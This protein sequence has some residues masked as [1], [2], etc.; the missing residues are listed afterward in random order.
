MPRD[1]YLTDGERMQAEHV[2]RQAADAL[3]LAQRNVAM[4]VT[5]NSS[6]LR[7]FHRQAADQ[8]R[9]DPDLVDAAEGLGAI[10]E[11]LDEWRGA[12]QAA[13]QAIVAR[14]ALINS[15]EG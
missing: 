14:D 12:S 7:Y 3:D 10:L 9:A 8:H 6:A 11:A 2:T 13:I 4:V 15:Q 1:K 5:E